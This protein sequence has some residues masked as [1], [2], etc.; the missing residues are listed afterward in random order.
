M[1]FREAF[2]LSKS[3]VQNAV[4]PGTVVLVQ[5]HEHGSDSE[6][7]SSEWPS[8]RCCEF[9]KH[10]AERHDASTAVSYGLSLTEP[11]LADC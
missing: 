1:S 2:A 11:G 5:R 8:T 9:A 7:S 6:A 4:P 10:L 3:D